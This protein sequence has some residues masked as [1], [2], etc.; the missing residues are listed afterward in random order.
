MPDKPLS[1]ASI[2]KELKRLEEL[3]IS[4]CILQVE[5]GDHE[6]ASNELLVFNRRHFLGTSHG[7]VISKKKM[8]V[9]AGLPDVTT[10]LDDIIVTGL[11]TDLI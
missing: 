5:L 8:M 4:W 7:P 11:T 2:D 3:D 9:V 10:Y 1:H 6:S